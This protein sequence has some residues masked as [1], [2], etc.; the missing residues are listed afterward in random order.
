MTKMI[1]GALLVLLLVPMA[2]CNDSPTSPDGPGESFTFELALTVTGLAT[3][4]FI[5]RFDWDPQGTFW[6]A[7]FNGFLI[8]VQN[9]EQTVWD[10]SDWDRWNGRIL[11]M[12]MDSQGRPWVSS[13]FG[14]AWFEGGGWSHREDFGGEPITLPV[15]ALAVAPN[16]DLLFGS[17]Q[18]GSGGLVMRRSGEWIKIEPGNSN[19]PST[20]TLD[21]DVGSNNEFWVSPSPTGGSGGLVRVVSG[22][23][24]EVYNR[25]SGLLF[26]WIDAVSVG[27]QGVWLGYRVPGFDQ[28]GV[29]E[30]GVQRLRPESDGLVTFDPYNTD[31]V[32]NRVP[33][34]DEARDGT[35][36]FTVAPDQDLL[37]C[38][39]CKPGIGYIDT[40]GRV[41]AISSLNSNLAEDGFFPWIADDHQ[42]T[43]HFAYNQSQIMRVIR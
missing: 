26:N 35:L 19:Y 16:G 33:A 1:R 14:Y 5:L 42:G 24:T 18:P 38:D 22:E 3:D 41:T 27:S 25:N 9:G 28:P 7:T 10:T 2:A 17:G 23:V 4:D 8:R 13:E 39:T 21:I 29:A 6:A 20:M 15:T 11:D 36:W 12:F 40:N 34:V 30:G 37:G 32:S 43:V 31:V